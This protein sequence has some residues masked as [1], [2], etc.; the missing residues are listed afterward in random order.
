MKSAAAAGSSS[1]MKEDPPEFKVMIGSSFLALKIVRKYN[2]WN[3][4][5]GS[6]PELESL[7]DYYIA[8]NTDKSTD[9]F[10][11]KVMREVVKILRIEH[12]NANSST[13][14]QLSQGD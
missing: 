11:G 14:D 8:K 4:C 13:T 7:V 3:G 2:A 12:G 6:R 9:E 5:V 10:R 1:S